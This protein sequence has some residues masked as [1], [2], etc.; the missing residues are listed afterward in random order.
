M[1][2]Q[3]SVVRW[4]RGRFSKYVELAQGGILLMVQ[5]LFCCLIFYTFFVQ[6]YQYIM[7]VLCLQLHFE[8]SITK[9]LKAL[10]L[11]II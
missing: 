2:K 9:F 7:T 8:S 10:Y 5:P 4:Q 11:S 1:L 6:S 3:C